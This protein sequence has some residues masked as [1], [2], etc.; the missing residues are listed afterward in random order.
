MNY[1]ALA[2]FNDGSCTSSR[3]HLQQQ[4]GLNHV[5][6]D[7]SS[8]S[9]PKTRAAASRQLSAGCLDPAASNYN[10]GASSHDGNVCS[11]AVLGCT[12]SHALNYLSTAE[13]ERTPSDC[14]MPRH[15]CT[16]RS[17]LNYDSLGAPYR[18]I[19]PAPHL[20]RSETAA[21]PR[22]CFESRCRSKC[23]TIRLCM[24]RAP[25]GLH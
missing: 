8:S 23:A 14:E 1:D 16:S 22:T 15:G 4:N 21:P 17:A 9:M 3:R 12:D 7:V 6:A 24:Y 25:S 18:Q 20:C 19:D 13:M 2:T 10:S 5:A 11:Y